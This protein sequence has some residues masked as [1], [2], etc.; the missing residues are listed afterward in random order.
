MPSLKLL[1]APDFH[2]C[3]NLAEEMR[4]DLDRWSEARSPVAL[5][6]IGQQGASDCHPN[7]CFDPQKQV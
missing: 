2:F 1:L 7:I 4:A 3:H 5:A 6:L